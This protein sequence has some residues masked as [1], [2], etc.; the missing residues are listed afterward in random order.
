MTS[1]F[2]ILQFLEK[3]TCHCH[4]PL[5]TLLVFTNFLSFSYLI[6]LI[7]SYQ[8]VSNLENCSKLST[9]YLLIQCL[10]TVLAS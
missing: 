8:E 1:W 10:P 2:I 9:F 3:P 6:I 7:T 4:L 5:P